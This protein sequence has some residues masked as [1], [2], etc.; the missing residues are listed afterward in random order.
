MDDKMDTA[1][2]I[3]NITSS[4]EKIEKDKNELFIIL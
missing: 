3:L 4:I 2:T 1:R